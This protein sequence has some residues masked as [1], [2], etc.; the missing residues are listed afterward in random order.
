MVI[1]ELKVL[2]ALKALK[3]LLD[4][5]NNRELATAAVWNVLSRPPEPRELQVLADYLDKR[6]DRPTEA[7]R[8]VV[9]SLLTST[10]FRFNH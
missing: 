9:W 1:L 7:V 5:K 6:S 4:L 3:G 10:E 8:Q 2:K